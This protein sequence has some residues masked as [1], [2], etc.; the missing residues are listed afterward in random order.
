M[1]CKKI[2]TFVP[3]LIPVIFLNLFPKFSSLGDAELRR[4][5]IDHYPCRFF[6][7]DHPEYEP[8][9][10]FHGINSRKW[11]EISLIYCYIILKNTMYNQ[12]YQNICSISQ[13]KLNLN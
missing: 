5:E 3:F 12:N 6:D 2:Q 4:I 11:V 9:N 7:K 1:Y 13:L 10:K 8:D